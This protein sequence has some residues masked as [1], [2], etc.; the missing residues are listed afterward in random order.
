MTP[1]E[2]V[3]SALE[4]LGKT[5]KPTGPHKW[6]ATCP[7]HAD[8]K[9]SLSITEETSGKVLLHCFGGCT[10][11]K[12][13]L[14]PLGLIKADLFPADFI[15]SKGKKNGSVKFTG[16]VKDKTP[17][18]KPKTLYATFDEA[19]A[20]IARQVGGTF[21]ESWIYQ[22]EDGAEAFQILRFNFTDGG[23]TFR[24]VY[25]N[26]GGYIQAD[27]PGKLPL[28][29]LPELNGQRIFICEG[30]KA[31]DAA[32]S[33][34]LS[35]TTSAHGGQAP[36][37]SDWQPLSGRECVL[38][39]DNDPAGA[40]YADK[41]GRI[42]QGLNPPARV[43]VV[44]LPGLP[45]KGDIYDYIEARDATESEDLKTSIDRLADDTPSQE[46]QTP[47]E[48]VSYN[49]TDAGNG[50]RFARQHGQKLRHCMSWGKWLVWDGRRWNKETGPTEARRLAV[51]TARSI[52][53]ESDRQATVADKVRF[54]AF[55]LRS[56]QRSGLDN[57]L[58]EARYGEPL[59]AYAKDF[60]SDPMLLNVLNGTIDL[61]T[62]KLE[63]HRPADMIT[64]CCPCRYD[65]AAELP[66]WDQ[67][68][69]KAAGGDRELMNFLQIAA[70]YS[71]TGQTGEEKLFFVHGPAAAGKS[72]FLEGIK[73][74]LGDYAITADFEAFLQKPGG[75]GIR[76]DIAR[77]E[78]ARLV[79]S[80][81]IDDGKKMA[82][83]L[84]KM[85][86]GGDT[87]A[88]RYL[89]QESF[90]FRPAF[91]LWLAANHAPRVRD[92]DAAMWRRILRIPFEVVIPIE[93]RDPQ[94]KKILTN[95]A[96]AGAAIL[97]WAV[98]GCLLWQEKG[99]IIPDCV[100]AATASYRE[101]MDPLRDFFQDCCTFQE[102]AIVPVSDL[103]KHYDQ[104][105]SDCGIKWTI[106]PRE[107]NDRVRG[108]GAEIDT[109]W[110]NGRSQ[111][112]WLGIKLR[113][114]L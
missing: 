98:R 11:I 47:S 23:K 97:A 76:N 108:K 71:L 9:P 45:P 13:I 22:R 29:R 49:L 31:S 33:I 85:L 64:K 50:E 27:P 78:G 86:T 8:T 48:P 16:P 107:F 19:A 14:E 93:E 77:L 94:I 112:C 89:Y 40:I 25:H 35:A 67:F 15:P 37:K 7:G 42:L 53:E 36:D 63:P 62:G 68:I 51:Q 32:R 90:E 83:G 91:K 100:Q 75:G 88:A 103:R 30:E 101:D 56:E 28:Y 105:A 73:T 109:K 12:Q 65:P 60:D 95:P 38:L 72:T 114:S 39:P 102:S 106:G 66:T 80:I 81:E 10:D 4:A 70:G 24:P 96:K 26:G 43:K 57:M 17:A 34:G 21:A 54:M 61:R 111:K 69:Y 113:D 5:I 52:R 20:A 1:I 58:N 84:V 3:L 92:D 18:P 74:T 44:K 41:V 6:Q 82:E 110:I 2:K 104:W 87:V 79:A 99:L 59:T 55:A 46:S